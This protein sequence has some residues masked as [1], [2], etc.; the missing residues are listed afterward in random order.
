MLWFLTYGKLEAINQLWRRP[1]GALFST[2]PKPQK[3]MAPIPAAAP[4][5]FANSSVADAGINQQNAAAVVAGGTNKTGGTGVS[6]APNTAGAS[7]LSGT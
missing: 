3:P 4:A 7:L 5:T 1:I 6:V 2:P